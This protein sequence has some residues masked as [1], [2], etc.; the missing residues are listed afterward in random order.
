MSE[1]LGARARRLQGKYNIT[2]EEYHQILVRQG[3]GCAICKR[4]PSYF[5]RAL[6]VDHDHGTR[7]VRGLLC[8]TC[9]SLLPANRNILD[10]LKAAVQYLESPPAVRAIG[11]RH[12]NAIRRKRKKAR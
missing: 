8:W 11:V 9:N 3:G 4:P 7:I 5:K 12:A 2:L 10:L 1:S 6:A